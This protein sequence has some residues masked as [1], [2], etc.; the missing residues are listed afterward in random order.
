MTSSNFTRT[1]FNGLILLVLL[2]LGSVTLHAQQ[3]YLTPDQLPNSMTILPPPPDSGSAAFA[4]DVELASNFFQLVSPA[5]KLEAIQEAN[6]DFSKNQP[7]K[8]II[9]FE[10]SQSTTPSLYTLILKSAID[11][12]ASTNAAKNHYKRIRPFEYLHEYSCTPLEEDLLR[13]NSSYPSGHAALGWAYALILAEI[14]PEKAS[15]ILDVGLEFGT[16]RNIC[17]VHW[18]SDVIAGRMMG[19]ST[20]AV[21]HGYPEWKGDMAKAKKE[22]SMM[23]KR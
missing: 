17:N 8:S 2:A 13:A 15:D 7:F 5:R 21:L 19:S 4:L 1:M 11:A 22:I 10:I 3:G 9:G 6:M 20:I 18:Y 14:F 23:S 12:N 16:S